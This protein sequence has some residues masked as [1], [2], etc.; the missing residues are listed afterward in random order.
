IQPL[1]ENWAGGIATGK[2]HPVQFDPATNRPRE[3]PMRHTV[4]RWKAVLHD[5]PPGAHELRCRTV[6]LAGHAQP[7]PRPFP[8]SGRNVIQTIPLEVRA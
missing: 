4:C 8:K 5:V 7:L 2:L 6:D 3:W 1:P